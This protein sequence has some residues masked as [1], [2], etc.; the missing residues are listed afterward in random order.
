MELTGDDLAMI[1]GA[2]FWMADKLKSDQRDRRRAL[3]A[4]RANKH[5]RRTRRHGLKDSGWTRDNDDAR[6]ALRSPPR[7]TNEI[8]SQKAISGSRYNL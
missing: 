8:L 2:L 3:S 6:I 1:F 5:S 4:A 7:M